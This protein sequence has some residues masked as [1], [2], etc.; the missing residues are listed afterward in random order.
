MKSVVSFAGI[1]GL[2]VILSLQSFAQA[3]VKDSDPEAELRGMIELAGGNESKI[4]EN[5][6]AFLKRFPDYR[7]SDIER[8]IFKLS[9]KLR[10]RDRAISYAERLV[11]VNERDLETLTQLIALLR[12]RHSGEDLKK[13]LE[14]SNQL[15]ERVETTL[16]A[17]KPG[18]MSEALWADRKERGRA[19]VHLLRGQVLA[20]LGEHEKAAT[21]FRRSYKAIKLAAT[22]VALAELAVKR[23]ARDEAVDY[24]LQALAISFDTEEEIDRKAVRS[25]LGQ[26]YAAKAGS[27]N[28]LGDRLL[29]TYDQ[30]AKERADYLATLE[31]P[32][33]NAGV[34][35][36]MLFKLTRPEGGT[37]RLGDFRGKV[38]VLNFWA[39]WCGPCRIEMP[40]FEKTMAKYKDDKDVVFLAVNTDED[41]PQVAPFL[42]SQK[43][44]LPVVYAEFLDEHYAVRSIPTTIVVDRNGNISFRQAGFNSRED[45]VAMLSE[46][47]EVAKR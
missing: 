35:D 42:K 7:R 13:A 4:V 45:F 46:K 25:K 36:P 11:T 28:G 19:S 20:D 10:D 31:V 44:K 14:Y 26:L 2:T 41:R 17:G 39:T 18:R 30:L 24:Y 5:L 43:F 12:E 21:E 40:L 6:E 47:I 8:E 27:E 23:Q 37:V 32:N 1:I 29:K 22:A 3:K 38:I 16:A 15:I 33:I 34:T 9:V